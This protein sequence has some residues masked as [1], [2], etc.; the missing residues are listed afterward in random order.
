[1]IVDYLKGG[2]ES[3]VAFS[4][5][6]RASRGSRASAPEQA[7]KQASRQARTHARTHSDTHPELS[8]HN[9]GILTA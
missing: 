4:Q 9:A 3:Q 5:V 2:N 1:M 8:P 6:S 7:G